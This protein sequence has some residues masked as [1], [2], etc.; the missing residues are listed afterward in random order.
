MS[1]DPNEPIDIPDISLHD[2]ELLKFLRQLVDASDMEPSEALVIIAAAANLTA[3]IER[4]I[5][6]AEE[7][8]PK[9]KLRVR[10][11]AN[12]SGGPSAPLD[13]A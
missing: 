12:Q 11:P 6:V 3:A 1:R 5:L 2:A 7:L 13:G 4:F 9:L 10:L 8:F